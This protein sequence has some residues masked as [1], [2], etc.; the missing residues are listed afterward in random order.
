MIQIKPN[1]DYTSSCPHCAGVL[2]PVEIV[3]QGIHVCVRAACRG[4]ERRIVED[5]AIG[6]AIDGTYQVDVDAG[7]LFGPAP[8]RPW[9][10][11]PLLRSLR[12]PESGEVPFRVTRFFETKNVVILNCLD[13]LY[14]H[15]L[16]KLL[17]AEGLLANASSLGVVV[18]VPRFLA[19]LVP[20]GVAETWV[21]D[22]PLPRAL[23]FHT[24]LHEKIRRECERFETVYV[25]RALSHPRN[26]HIEKFTR[27]PKHDFAAAPPRV[28]FV[29]RED[30]TWTNRPL[31]A[32]AL[33]RLG[34]GRVVA[35]WQR[36]RVVAL[37]E[38]LRKALPEAAFGV[39]GLGTSGRFPQWIADDRTSKYTDDVERRHCEI[40]SQSRLVIGVHGSNM[41]LP[42]GLAGLTID[43]VPDDRW[44]NYA[45]DVL[46]QEPDSRM[47]AYRYRYLPIDVSV[48]LL[49]QI[50]RWQVSDYDE[51]ARHMLMD[52]AAPDGA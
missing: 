28:T 24:D 42:S 2:D 25:S 48:D 1:I 11:E 50:A 38:R 13:F 30:R 32:A 5:L 47:A 52:A 21:V 15:S 29:W 8:R 34:L 40:Y 49:A 26:F 31:V 51:F 39:A 46:Y 10:G 22:L 36:R 19:W 33:R 20:D 27:V 23:G 16:L 37:F 17:N 45:Q 9:F 18:I 12:S 43:L 4:C 44:G 41:L 6:H 7:L 14:G 3:W 35:H